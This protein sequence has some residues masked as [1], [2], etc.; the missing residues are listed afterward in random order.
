MKIT[1]DKVVGITYELRVGNAQEETILVEKIDTSQIFYFLYG[2][3]GLP[4]GFE[5][6]L[7]GIEKGEDFKFSLSVEQGFG[8]KDEDAIVFI[9]KDAFK[10]DGEIDQGM[11]KVGNFVPMVDDRGHQV[12]G[13]IME[14]EEEQVLVDFNHPLVGLELH[15]EGKVEEVRDATSEEIAHGHVHGPGGHH[16]H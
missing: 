8:E 3:S 15:F 10:I 6:K 13:K 14:I 7:S 9:P 11:L 12:Q 1:D 16:H 2:N 4:E 5:E